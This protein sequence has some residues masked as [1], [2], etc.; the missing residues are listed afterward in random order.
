MK[1]IYFLWFCYLIGA[2]L[3][4][5][6]KS[7]K[8]II[9]TDSPTAVTIFYSDLDQSECLTPWQKNG[10]GY[11]FSCK[12]PEKTFLQNDSNQEL[13]C[14][15][16]DLNNNTSS[17]WFAL[18]PKQS[19]SIDRCLNQYADNSFL[20]NTSNILNRI[21]EFFISTQRGIFDN[22][23]NMVMQNKDPNALFSWITPNNTHFL[24]PELTVLQ[25]QTTA[26]QVNCQLVNENNYPEVEFT[27]IKA[28][29]T[30][31]SILNL[32]ELYHGKLEEGQNY[33]LN[34]K[35]VSDADAASFSHEISFYIL[36][37]F[38]YNQ[39][40]KFLKN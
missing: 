39:L 18:K 17:T 36:S 16:Y 12:K 5:S 23:E 24:Q 19:I 22:G 21:S 33:R 40:K 10:C 3:A 29:S 14:K 6:A 38:E 8:Y 9:A 7:N 15:L 31:I 30:E 32:N 35:A 25:F 13:R 28:L 20:S 4:V 26:K 27:P 34:C 1:S 2:N 11:L 37:Q